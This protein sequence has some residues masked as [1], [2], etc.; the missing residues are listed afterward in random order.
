[1]AG[2]SYRALGRPLAAD[3]PTVRIVALAAR[4]GGLPSG[5]R[6]SLAVLATLVALFIAVAWLA[7][8]LRAGSP[9]A[10]TSRRA[11]FGS[12]ALLGEMLSATDDEQALLEVIRTAAVEATGAASGRVVAGGD[13]ES[14]NHS[15]TLV[16]S[17]ETGEPGGAA[18]VLVPP[19]AGFAPEAAAT[20][21]WLGIHG[22]TALKNA[23]RHRL[24]EQHALTD[25]LTGLANRRRFTAALQTECGRSKRFETP[26]AVLLADLDGF[27]A[28][29]DRFGHVAGDEV[30]KAFART[31]ERCAREID[32]PARLGGDEFAVLLPQ[33]DVDGAR[34]VAERLRTELRS[35]AGLPVRVTASFGVSHHPPSEG[36][37]E[38]LARADAC[39]YR[40]KRA[41]RDMVVVDADAA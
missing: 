7:S 22:S 14:I 30:L 25:D 34:H 18:I 31:L 35:A 11:A 13:V 2:H 33:T 9:E 27:K 4:S 6:L 26:L 24:A 16:V 40:A 12:M 39:L 15:A 28:I 8:P 20:A 41:G 21:D 38:L 37:D 5:W 17:L 10:P 36:A 32:L 1:V 23:H 19:P 29:N 3:R